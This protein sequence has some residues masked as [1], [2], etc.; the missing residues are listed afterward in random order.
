MSD[1]NP[2]NQPLGRMLTLNEV[3]RETSLG[4]STIFNRMKDGS[5]PLRRKLSPNRIGWP[6]AEIEAWKRRT[7]E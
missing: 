5:F 3:I 4:R 1:M 6:E 2:A 7:A